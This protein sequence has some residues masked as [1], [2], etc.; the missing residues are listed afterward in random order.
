M[1]IFRCALGVAAAVVA[2]ASHSAATRSLADTHERHSAATNMSANL[3]IDH[4]ADEEAGEIERSGATNGDASMELVLLGV[5]PTAPRAL[6][7]KAVVCTLEY[8]AR[9]VFH[10]HRLCILRLPR[11]LHR[12]LHTPTRQERRAAAT[13]TNLERHLP[14]FA[15]SPVA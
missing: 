2:G 9:V 10:P 8:S 13:T 12:V 5:L 14:F 7:S 3:S 1:F 6:D 15:T 4:H 11:V